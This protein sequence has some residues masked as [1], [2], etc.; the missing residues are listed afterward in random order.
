MAPQFLTAK[1][2]R[3]TTA[4]PIRNIGQVAAIVAMAADQAATDQAMK[5]P[6]MAGT[7]AINAPIWIAAKPPAMAA[8]AMPTAVA[9]ALPSWSQLTNFAK[10]TTI[11]TITLPILS[12]AVPKAA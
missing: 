7:A 9:G 12:K 3:A 1:I 5:P 11:G 4:T 2:I 6:T 10:L 8:N